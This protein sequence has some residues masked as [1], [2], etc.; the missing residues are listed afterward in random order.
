MCSAKPDGS[1]GRHYR[2]V[3]KFVWRPKEEWVAIPVPAYLP[4]ELVNRAHV[5]LEANKAF[6]RKHPVQTL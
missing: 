1:G 5:M 6:E 4:R 2:K 3:R